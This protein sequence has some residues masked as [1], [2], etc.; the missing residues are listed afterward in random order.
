MPT[1]RRGGTTPNNSP[2][3]VGEEHI[4][5]HA[6]IHGGFDLDPAVFDWRNPVV[7]ITITRIDDD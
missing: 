7:E 1:Y 4:H 5:V 3:D 6:G 2:I